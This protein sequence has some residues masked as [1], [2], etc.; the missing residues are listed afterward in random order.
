[1]P[2]G[3]HVSQFGD[4][5][6][7]QRILTGRMKPVY[8]AL[9]KAWRKEA[10]YLNKVVVKGIQSQAPGGKQFKPLAPTTLAIRRFLGFRGTKALLWHRNLLNAVK[11]TA[12]GRAGTSNYVV[13]VGI[14]RDAKSPAGKSLYR[15]GMIAEIGSKPIVVKVT[16]KM[17]RFLFAA[18]RSLRKD[19]GVDKPFWLVKGKAK[20]V[21]VIRIPARPVFAPIWA[22]EV[23]ASA[24][25]IVATAA[26]ELKGTLSAP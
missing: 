10:R 4:W 17:R 26:A 18:F 25:R 1:M 19:D 16:P 9:G 23:K 13:F 5:A 2:A 21:I 24:A 22:Q 14:H 12:K 11:V 15:I 6:K 3:L 8:V 7:A 20:G